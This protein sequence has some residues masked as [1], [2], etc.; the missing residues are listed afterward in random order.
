MFSPFRKLRN[1]SW[2]EDA[3]FR[4]KHK[5]GDF[6]GD[7]TGE[8]QLFLMSMTLTLPLGGDFL[9]YNTTKLVYWNG[10][11]GREY[12]NFYFVKYMISVCCSTNAFKEE[13]TS[14]NDSRGIV[15]SSGWNDLRGIVHG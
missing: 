5:K 12:P 9:C 2:K 15:S 13:L 10:L 7:I 6:A 3:L 14:W 8:S 1:L 11:R 4:I